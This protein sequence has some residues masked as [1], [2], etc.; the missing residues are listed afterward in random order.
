MENWIFIATLVAAI[1]TSI[2]GPFFL[3][4]ARTRTKKQASKDPIAE[5]INTNA[6]IQSQI[7]ELLQKLGADRVWVSQFHNGGHFYPT[8]KS[9]TKFSIF[10]EVDAPNVTRLLETFQNIP[11]SFFPSAMSKLYEDGEIAIADR[12]TAEELYGLGDAMDQHNIESLYNVSIYDLKNKFVGVLGIA[13]NTAK[14]L[15][16]EDWILIRQKG[17]AIGVLLNNYFEDK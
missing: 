14:E 12:N 4:W 2:L 3:E 6:I 17:G 1:I 11:T 9:I 8:G 15:D 7:D 13:Y 5:A 10:F 16:L